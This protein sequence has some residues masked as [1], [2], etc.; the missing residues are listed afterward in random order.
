MIFFLRKDS[1][2]VSFDCLDN[3]QGSALIIVLIVMAVLTLV[4]LSTINTASI[5]NRIVRNERVYQENFYLAES[6][7]NEA[8]QKIEN[9][10]NSDN[11]IPYYSSWL[12]MHDVVDSNNN[13]MNFSD[14]D[15]WVYSVSSSDNSEQAAVNTD[16]FFQVYS[17]GLQEVAPW[18]SVTQTRA[19]MNMRCSG[20]ENQQWQRHH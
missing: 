9:E 18:T 19:C 11:L 15:N 4:G 12:W 6:G 3:H 20:T 13:P 7:V 14:P 10:T 2:K 16:A 1:L 17:K 8:A 5:E